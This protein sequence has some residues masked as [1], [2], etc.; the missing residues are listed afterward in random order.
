MGP[1]SETTEG[2]RGGEILVVDF[3]SDQSPFFNRAI[4]ATEGSGLMVF[5]RARSTLFA[6]EQ[7]IRAELLRERTIWDNFPKPPRAL[8]RSV[9]ARQT[10][11]RGTRLS[12]GGWR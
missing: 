2:N 8:G 5:P 10:L 3:V 4:V 7:L 11:L 12:C 9:S 1:T 6:L